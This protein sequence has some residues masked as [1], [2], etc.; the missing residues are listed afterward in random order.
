MRSLLS[1]LDERAFTED[2]VEENEKIKARKEG[3]ICKKNTHLKDKIVLKHSGWHWE[4]AKSRVKRDSK[5]QST[6][7]LHRE[8][9]GTK[10]EP[11]TSFGR[12]ELPVLNEK[13]R[14]LVD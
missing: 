7:R 13:E 10:T 2:R 12:R 1:E 8:E 9:H 3:W 14:S 4:V 6:E 11:R 5:G